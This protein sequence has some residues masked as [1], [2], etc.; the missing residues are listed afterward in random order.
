MHSNTDR[1][2]KTINNNGKL[3]RQE[4]ETNKKIVQPTTTDDI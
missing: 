2:F 1:D 3:K 4:S